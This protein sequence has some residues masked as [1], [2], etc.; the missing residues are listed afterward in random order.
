M[1]LDDY[2]G[3]KIDAP[4]V[5]FPV[6][7]PESVYNR[8]QYYWLASPDDE[9]CLMNIGDHGTLSSTRGSVNG[10]EHSTGIRPLVYLPVSV[11]LKPSGT[12]NVWNINY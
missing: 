11:S 6:K 9:D 5:Y 10:C 8:V 3:Y 1:Y 2:T 7:S 4:N 12:T